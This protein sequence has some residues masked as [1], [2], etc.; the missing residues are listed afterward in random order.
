[1]TGWHV[2]RAYA[3]ATVYCLGAGPSL[4]LVNPESLRGKPYIACNSALFWARSV[5]APGAYALTY[6][7]QYIRV[8]ETDYRAFHEAGGE[9]VV[10]SGASH[11]PW[12]RQLTTELPRGLC[13]SPE[14]L[15]H[16]LNTGHGAINLAYHLGAA[17]IVLIGYDMRICRGGRVHWDGRDI[18]D[19]WKYAILFARAFKQIAA[20]L[21]EAGVSVLNATPHSALEAF[22]KIPLAD[23]FS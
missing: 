5:W 19:A 23:A 2:P 6:H 12:V 9:V 21:K 16:G 4:N 15:G 20:D 18:E 14:G 17:R 13:R 11:A 8:H 7:D 22:P 10:T 1:M 3:G